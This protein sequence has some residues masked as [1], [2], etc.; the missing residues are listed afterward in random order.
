M[1]LI[2]AGKLEKLLLLKIVDK[3]LLSSQA[4]GDKPQVATVA[5]ESRSMLSVAAIKGGM[6]IKGHCRATGNSE[7]DQT[8]KDEL[9][10]REKPQQN[11]KNRSAKAIL[12]FSRERTA[13]SQR[14]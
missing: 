9:F 8:Q 5:A 12:A 1:G 13:H 4:I 2:E 10:P 14:N 11:T 7:A 3:D 6:G